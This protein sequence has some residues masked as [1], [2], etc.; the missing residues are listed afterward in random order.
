MTVPA[1]FDAIDGGD[2]DSNSISGFY[3]T[4]GITTSGDITI[5]S[6]GGKCYFITQGEGGGSVIF[7]PPAGF[8]SS[9]AY[10]SVRIYD[11]VLDGSTQFSLINANGNAQARAVMNS[12]GSIS[13]YSGSTLLGRSAINQVVRGAIYFLEVFLSVSATVG[14]MTVWLNGNPTAV[15]SVSGL[16]TEADSTSVNVVG[17]MAGATNGYAVGFRDIYLHDGTGAAPFNGPLGPGG[18]VWLPAATLVSAGSFLPNGLGTLVAN[19]AST[20]PNPGVDFDSSSTVG[21]AVTFGVTQLPSNAAKVI[22]VRAIDYS[23]KTDTGSRALQKSLTFGTAVVAGTENYLA[24]GAICYQDP[25]VTTDPNT[26]ALFGTEGS[27]AIAAVNAVH[28]T[29]TVAA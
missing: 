20:P 13:I 21:D 27:T 16:N 1:Q 25:W 29:E 2:L 24:E 3:S 5:Q 28:L 9:T 10:V 18:C 7:K 17:A 4:R 12:D 14:A 26:G 19:A 23:Y 11:N 15:L 6:I 22:A 8:S